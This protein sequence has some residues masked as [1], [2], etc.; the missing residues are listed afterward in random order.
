MQQVNDG[1]C[2]LIVSLVVDGA[3]REENWWSG[4]Y[5]ELLHTFHEASG[6]ISS[7]LATIH[8]EYN[9]E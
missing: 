1:K 3:P 6:F 9:R 4:S 7:H 5:Q 8:K 2:R